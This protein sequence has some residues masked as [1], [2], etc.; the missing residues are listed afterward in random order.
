MVN[1][2]Q[3]KQIQSFVQ[4]NPKSGFPLVLQLTGINGSQQFD[5]FTRTK[6]VESILTVMDTDG[7]KSYIL[8][9]LG[10]VNSPKHTEEYGIP[11]LCIDSSD[12][13]VWTGT[14]PLSILGECGSQLS[15]RLWCTTDP[16]PRAMNG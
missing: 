16:Y 2:T 15:S 6:T 12:C 8:S 3:A 11:L 14:L 9:L 10:Q 13:D 7:I 4:K 5:K 1:P